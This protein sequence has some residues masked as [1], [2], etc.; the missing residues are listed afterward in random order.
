M[1]AHRRA[2]ACARGA[3]AR[4]VVERELGLV[5]LAGD[6]SMPGAAEPVVKLLVLLAELLGLHDMKTEQAVTQFQSMLERSDDLLIDSRAD[7]ERIDHG[8]DRM[9]LFLIEIDMVPQIARLAVDSGPAVAVDANLLEEIFVILAVNLVD[10]RADLDLGAF[11]QRQQMF[12][13]LMRG[14]NREGLAAPRA[15]R[16]PHG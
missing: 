4:G 14:A 8:F 11:R 16:R 10:G 13:H 3:R 2:D 7:D 9:L 5:H 1:D 12:H 6:K 15:G